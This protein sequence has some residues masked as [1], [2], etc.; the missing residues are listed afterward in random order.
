MN[1]TDLLQK[2]ISMGNSQNGQNPLQNLMSKGNTQK[3]PIDHQRFTE[4]AAMLNKQ[5]LAK[6]VIQAR[7]QGISEQ[8]IEDGLNFLLKLR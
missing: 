8:E 5:N 2:M 7:Q 3:T 1:N 4:G 6:L